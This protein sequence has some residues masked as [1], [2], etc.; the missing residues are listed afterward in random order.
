[1]KFESEPKLLL[2][3]YSFYVNCMKEEFLFAG[4]MHAVLLRQW[5]TRVK[6]RDWYD[7]EWF[8]KRGTPLNLEHLKERSVESG[9]WERK[10]DLNAGTFLK[11]LHEK[12]DKLDLKLAKDDIQRF[13]YNPDE[14]KIWSKDYFKNLGAFIQF[15]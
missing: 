10:R 8:I 11:L 14:V 12:I 2:R 15:S 6:G 7:L 5:K 4:K 13:I 1:M 3:P 9:N